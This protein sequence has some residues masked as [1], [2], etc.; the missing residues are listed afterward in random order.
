MPQTRARSRTAERHDREKEEQCQ[1]GFVGPS[2]MCSFPVGIW[3]AG[4][5]MQQRCWQSGSWGGEGESSEEMKCHYSTSSQPKGIIAPS[6]IFEL[7]SVNFSEVCADWQFF[8][9]I[10]KDKKAWNKILYLPWKVMQWTLM[11]G[12]AIKSQ[13]VWEQLILLEQDAPW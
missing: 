1:A 12:A 4:D 2:R 7:A 3:T 10:D 8:S 5:A 13:G 9:H 6:L 11:S